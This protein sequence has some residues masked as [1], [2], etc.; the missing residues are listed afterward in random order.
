[1]HTHVISQM[2]AIPASFVDLPGSVDLG[3]LQMY[4]INGPAGISGEKKDVLVDMLS[5]VAADAFARD[6]SRE[7]CDDVRQHVFGSNGL[8]VVMDSQGQV[9]AFC[10]WDFVILDFIQGLDILY[11]TGICVVSEW[12]GRG[13]GNRLLK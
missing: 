6:C 7:L 8:L 3:D 9:V 12:Q 5:P 13:V 11:L 1:M 2:G 10:V 4:R